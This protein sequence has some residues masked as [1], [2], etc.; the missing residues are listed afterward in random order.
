M[1]SAS[2]H[3]IF[4][5]G[6]FEVVRRKTEDRLERALYRHAGI[7]WWLLAGRH[8]ETTYST[9]ISFP[10][11]KNLKLLG[12]GQYICHIQDTDKDLL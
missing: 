11:N 2:T 8:E 9:D 5:M 6:F 12:E 3:K 1:K 7:D 10:Q 4:S